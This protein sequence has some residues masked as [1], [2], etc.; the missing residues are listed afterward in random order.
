MLNIEL[1]VFYE[2]EEPM[3]VLN[4]LS[5]KLTSD[6]IVMEGNSLIDVPL[7]EVLDTHT[8][9][10]AAVTSL[11]KEYDMSK[12]AKGPKLID[13]ESSDIFGI[14]GCSDSQLRKG[15]T[16]QFNRMVMKTCKQES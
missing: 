8:L 13:V 6:F 2:D 11:A 1:V 15:S 16:H 12:L 10:G 3:H 4:M 7:D 9:T 5:T 14:S